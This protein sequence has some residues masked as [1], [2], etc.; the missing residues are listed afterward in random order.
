VD[1]GGVPYSITEE[2]VSVYRLHSLIPGES[3]TSL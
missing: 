2:F 1:M 3:T